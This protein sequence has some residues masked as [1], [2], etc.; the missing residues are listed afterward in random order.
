MYEYVLRFKEAMKN[1]RT[2]T[3]YYFSP[4][5]SHQASKYATQS[6]AFIYSIPLSSSIT[7]LATSCVARQQRDVRMYRTRTTFN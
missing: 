5:F 4:I 1:A 6:P 7:T 2:S 3:G